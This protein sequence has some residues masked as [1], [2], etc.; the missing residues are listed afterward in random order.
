[1]PTVF[2]SFRKVTLAPCL[3]FS[4]IVA[5]AQHS[6]LLKQ[7]QWTVQ[8]SGGCSSLPLLQ[9]NGPGTLFDPASGGALSDLQHALAAPL[10]K[11]CPGVREAILVNGRGRRLIK[12]EGATASIPDPVP[13]PGPVPPPGR[14]TLPVAT[15]AA[16][17]P[18]STQASPAPAPVKGSAQ[19][20]YPTP[21]SAPGTNASGLPESPFVDMVEFK[22]EARHP[23]ASENRD[24]PLQTRRGAQGRGNYP[25][26]QFVS[27]IDRARDQHGARLMLER[28]QSGKW[29]PSTVSFTSKDQ[30]FATG[31]SLYLGRIIA[32]A[33]S[34]F[35]VTLS[36]NGVVTG[37]ET[38]S[39]DN[40]R[41][42]G[43][44]YLATG[45]MTW[46]GTETLDLN[47][48]LDDWTFQGQ[49]DGHS[50]A[51]LFN[52]VK[53]TL[54]A[55][56]RVHRDLA[57]VP[58]IDESRT[59]GDVNIASD[60]A[61]PRALIIG[62]LS[63]RN[64]KG[65]S[66]LRF[67]DQGVLAVPLT[68]R[69]GLDLNDLHYAVTTAEQNTGILNAGTLS[70]P[71]RIA[72]DSQME[73][74]LV[75]GT[76]FG[77][78][79]GGVNLVVTVSYRKTVLGRRSLTVATEP[80]YRD[81]KVH[82][83]DDTAPR[84]KAVAKYFGNDNAVYGDPAPELAASASRD[85]MA[86][87]WEAVFYSQGV[88]GYKFD[89]ERAYRDARRLLPQLEERARG[90]DA[91]AL[92]LFFYVC[93]LGLEGEVG[94]ADAGQFLDRSASAG[95]LP[96]KF[97]R[98]LL[99]SLG[100]DNSNAV[101]AL[102]EVYD[103][104]VKRA[105]FVL[106]RVYEQGF[107]VERDPQT[108]FTW[109]Q[110]GAEFGDPA[111]LLGL[112]NL[113]AR[114]VGETQPDAAKAMQLARQAAARKY[115][116]AY[117]YI[118]QAYASGRQGVKQDTVAASKAF[119]DAADLGDRDGMLALGET[120]LGG[121][122][123]FTTDEQA[124]AYWIRQAAEQESP[125]AMLPLSNC[126]REGKGFEKDEIA[127]RYWFNQAALHGVIPGDNQGVDAQRQIFLDFWRSADFSPS[128]VYV[129]RYGSVVGDSGPDFLGG[130]LSGMLGAAMNYYGQRQ[131]MIDG[132]EFIQE[133]RGRKVYGGT[134]SSAFTSKLRLKAGQTVSIH[135]YGIISTGMFSGAANANG[136][137]QAWPEYRVISN[138]PTSAL[139]GRIGDSP[140]QLIGT[141]AQITAPSDGLVAFALNARDYQNYKGYFDLVVEV[142]GQE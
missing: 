136:L 117:V 15:T 60:P 63:F 83:P 11:A 3:L 33:P 14:V 17:A 104:G 67:S 138:I 99:L 92:Y 89:Q 64:D 32:S 128:Y 130:A 79:A 6:E 88:A 70:G 82:L 59:K 31:G 55:S 140:W 16:V 71:F 127:A 24:E 30:S 43:N 108:A 109:Y 50:S 81:S 66:T 18:P 120:L 94:I 39:T 100:K 41:A 75:I 118:G 1:M 125:G 106:G 93:Q 139:I 49:M 9:V 53:G 85:P 5:W 133:R 76:G 95:F 69:A 2:P 22:N 123:G 56:D 135:A 58:A 8:L 101:A 10:T 97:D 37:K 121:A 114:G 52:G 110:R 46:T 26:G 84:L 68:N 74:P 119:K 21:A 73:L 124:G 142:P 98:A 77:I 126:Y 51:R 90:G 131:T 137:G 23:T 20:L 112:A 57:I 12:I 87:M 132:L 115:S 48:G 34:E 113:T 102:K 96:A 45:T 116:G 47:T 28:L 38:G 44:A 40:L 61:N 78:P 19:P 25:L 129:N 141:R 80:F 62:N 7:G 65:A 86:A 27:I 42:S 54:T 111:A 13:S 36:E 122:P 72:R 134:V 91:E 29:V 103:A 35:V 105:A 107:G 4:A